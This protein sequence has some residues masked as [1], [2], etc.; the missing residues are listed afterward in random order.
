[1]QYRSQVLSI[2]KMSHTTLFL[3]SNG[4]I[5]E[6]VMQMYAKTN[7]IKSKKKIVMGVGL[8]YLIWSKRFTFAAE[9]RITCV[10]WWKNWLQCES[11]LQPNAQEC[12]WPTMVHTVRYLNLAPDNTK[13][14]VAQILFH[15]SLQKSL[16]IA[17]RKG[18]S[19]IAIS[20]Q[21]TAPIFF[22]TQRL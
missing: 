5:Y 9:W 12:S 17:I 18:M 1:M 19:A 8:S 13:L 21:M 4:C 2:C 16:M 6:I 20:G 3:F 11:S 22:D 14:N 7:I 10:R 15:S